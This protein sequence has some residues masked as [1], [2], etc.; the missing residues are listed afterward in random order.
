MLSCPIRTEPSR[1]ISPGTIKMNAACAAVA[2]APANNKPQ[3]RGSCKTRFM[4]AD[5]LADPGRVG[6]AAIRVKP[7]SR[8]PGSAGRVCQPRAAFT[9][10]SRISSASAKTSS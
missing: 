7:I 8:R 4:D 5:P 6:Q 10:S 1:S 9:L 3:A 2:V